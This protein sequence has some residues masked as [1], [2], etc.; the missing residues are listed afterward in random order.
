MQYTKHHHV[1]VWD[2]TVLQYHVLNGIVKLCSID[3][4]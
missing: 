4:S 2:V 1:F 3:G